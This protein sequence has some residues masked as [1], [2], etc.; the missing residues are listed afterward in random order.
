[1]TTDAVTGATVRVIKGRRAGQPDRA[2]TQ[3]AIDTC[4]GCRAVTEAAAAPVPLRGA[5]HG[6]TTLAV[7]RSG[8]RVIK[9][10]CTDQA[11][12]ATTSMTTR[13]VRR[14]GCVREGAIAPPDPRAM[15]TARAITAASGVV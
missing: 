6:V 14:R 8:N 3:V 2:N 10:R 9:R 12:R 4:S 1:M 15:V 13:T 7:T 11:R 5:P